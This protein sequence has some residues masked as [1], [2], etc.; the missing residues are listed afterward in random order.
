MISEEEKDRIVNVIEK[1]GEG[2]RGGEIIGHTKSG[3]P[4]YKGSEHHKTMQSYH[5]FSSSMHLAHAKRIREN[6]AH[7]KKKD[8]GKESGQRT[9]MHQHI[10]EK[11]A[12]IHEDIAYMKSHQK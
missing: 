10:L 8:E 7:L 1:A 11:K 2:S 12:K 5:N 3:K 4:I 6:I 9:T